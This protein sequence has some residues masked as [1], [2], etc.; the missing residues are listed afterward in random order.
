[1]KVTVQTADTAQSIRVDRTDPTEAVITHL[2]DE[3]SR[4]WMYLAPALAAALGRELAG[5]EPVRT[6][7]RAVYP[8][9]LTPD[10]EIE[11]RVLDED[12][13][14]G[15]ADFVNRRL[16]AAGLP[17]TAYVEARQVF[18]GPWESVQN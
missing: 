7:Y 14:A 8:K 1:M 10:S 6:E 16:A 18:A 17:E 9:S 2:V 13:A 5:V 4:G 12:D 11:T 15:M 3:V